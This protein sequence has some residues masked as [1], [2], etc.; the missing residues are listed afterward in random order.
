ME[1]YSVFLKRSAA[2]ELEELGTE[3]DRRRIVDRIAGLAEDPRP[4]GCQTLAG[5][6]DR[7]RVRQGDHRI[8]YSVDDPD[9]TVTVWKIGHRRDVYRSG[10]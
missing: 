8:V 5:R 7:L 9:R 3:S 10:G 4:A 2:K 6:P 1:S